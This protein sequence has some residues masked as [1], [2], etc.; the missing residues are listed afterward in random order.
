MNE[1]M[2]GWVG[3]WVDVP[4]SVVWLEFHPPPFVPGGLARSVGA[5]QALDDEA[6]PPMG[7]WVGG[8]FGSGRG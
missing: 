2:N 1:W 3:G 8:W 5:V 6:F 7:G 4:V